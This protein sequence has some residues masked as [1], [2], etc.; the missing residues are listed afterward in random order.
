M[1]DIE[2]DFPG[3]NG[4][5]TCLCLMDQKKILE[6]QDWFHDV[7][8][9]PSLDVWFALTV[10]VIE[11]FR[12]T[13]TASKTSKSIPSL[14]SGADSALPAALDDRVAPD[15]AYEFAKTTKQSFSDLKQFVRY[16]YIGANNK[17]YRNRFHMSLQIKDNVDCLQSLDADDDFVFSCFITAKT[18]MLAKE[19]MEPC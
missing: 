10:E 3:T 8:N 12:A 13:C 18:T 9:N 19:E 16:L 2:S 1:E 6:V 7:T 15:L 14:T 5:T 17:G 4:A 11:E